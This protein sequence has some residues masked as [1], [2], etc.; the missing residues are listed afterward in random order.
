M[1]TLTAAEVRVLGVLIEKG[2]TTPEYYPLSLNAAVNACNQKSSRD[3]VMELSEADV[4]SALF[5]LEQLGLV[6]VLADSRVSKF[7]HLAYGRL[8]LGRP[9]TAVLGLL[10]LRGAQTAAE[11]RARAERMYSFD[12][13]AAVTAVLERLAAREE[14]LVVQLARQPGARESRWMHR[15]SG[16]VD[17]AAAPAVSTATAATTN[18]LQE[19]MAELE[20][21]VKALEERVGALEGSK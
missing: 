17:S 10:L 2:I 20:R 8:A 15:L 9:E 5:E 18:D 13:V 7:E 21:L 6:R 11:L 3:P 4:R 1:L 12:D 19:R 14:A 16:D